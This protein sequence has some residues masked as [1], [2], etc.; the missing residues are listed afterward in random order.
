M[1]SST[2]SR[3]LPVKDHLHRLYM[4]VRD[5]YWLRLLLL[6]G[7]PVG[8]LL[9]FF[10]L[11]LMIMLWL[12]FHDG[13]PP[14]SYTLENYMRLFDSLYLNVLWRTLTMTV[15]VTVLVTAVGYTL[16]YSVVQFSR[17]TTL[18]LLLVI[19]PFWTNYIVRMYALINIFQTGGAMSWVLNTVGLLN[20]DFGMLF[21]HEAVLIGLAYVWLPLATLPFYASLSNL[22]TDLIDASKDL[23][24]GPIKTF[25]SVTLPLTYNGLIAGIILVAIPTFGAF[26]TP[27]LLGGTDQIMIGNVIDQQ[28]NQAFNWAFGAA[29]GIFVSLIV[30]VVLGLSTRIGG[31]I[32]GVGGDQQ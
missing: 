21:T 23:G 5:R 10:V 26:V 15:Q 27:A 1:A 6:V 7:I 19:L 28:F 4:S 20:E 12:S 16:A 11:P 31:S 22:D 30:L 8:V 3:R 25:Y 32:V 24:A 18:L 29:I 17:R 2:P 13:M 14:A 9:L